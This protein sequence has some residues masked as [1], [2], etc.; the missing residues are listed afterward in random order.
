ML[1]DFYSGATGLSGCFVRDFLSGALTWITW[2]I[3]GFDPESENRR[4]RKVG[5]YIGLDMTPRNCY[6][7]FHDDVTPVDE[8]FPNEDACK[9]FLKDRRWPDGEVTCPRCANKK[10]WA[11]KS[12]PF[13]WQC[14]KCNKTGYRFSIIAGTIFENTGY[15]LKT[16][17][18]VL[19]Q[20]LNSKKGVSAKQISG[21]SDRPI[22]LRGFSV[23]GS[24]RR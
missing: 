2:L 23:I 8:T 6:L 11:L 20:M 15:P 22:L 13:H 16:W 4:P 9:Q 7:F 1:P 19:W 17:F 5:N 12:R 3:L 21:R 24:A 14:Q 18:E 10:S